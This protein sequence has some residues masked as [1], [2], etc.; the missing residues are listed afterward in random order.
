[1]K[2]RLGEILLGRQQIDAAAL[3]RGIQEQS[4]KASRL[5]EILLERR[6]VDKEALVAALVEIM[7]VPYLDVT[8]I[9]PDPKA[10]SRLTREEVLQYW[11]VPVVFERNALVVVMAEPQDPHAVNTLQF[12][13]GQRI[14]PRLGFR[15]EVFSA[16]EENY[17]R[18]AV[19]RAG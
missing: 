4:G 14:S 17:P 6:L 13:C 10:L 16:M 9:T 19:L 2:R 1:M 7:R 5:G 3:E 12:L 18:M 15:Q 11:A 8:A